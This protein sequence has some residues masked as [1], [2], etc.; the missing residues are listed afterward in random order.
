ML[1]YLKIF[2]FV[3]LSFFITIS[4][5]KPQIPQEYLLHITKSENDSVCTM[6]KVNLPRNYVSLQHNI[7]MYIEESL[8]RAG[9]YTLEFIPQT[10]H[11]YD[12]KYKLSISTFLNQGMDAKSFMEAYIENSSI[13]NKSV[14][15]IEKQIIEHDGYT[16][17]ILGLYHVNRSK[18]EITYINYYFGKNNVS[19]IEFDKVLAEDEN[20]AN[21]YRDSKLTATQSFFVIDQYDCENNL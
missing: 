20:P 17:V 1:R 18:R 19:G 16:Q 7:D 3:I 14:E 5:A 8:R 10:N 4:I 9:Q 13:S 12:W 15:V 2:G 21:A 6:L 11:R